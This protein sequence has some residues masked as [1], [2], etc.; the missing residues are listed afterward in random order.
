MFDNTYDSFKKNAISFLDHCVAED[1]HLNPEKIQIDC[2]KVPF[3]GHT[4]SKDGVH[5][6]KAKVELIQ[7]WPIPENVKELQSFLGTVNYLSKFLAFLSD[8]C[9]PLQ[10]LLKNNAEFT[11][12]ETHTQAFNQLKEHVSLNISLQFFDCSKKKLMQAS[13]TLVLSCYSLIQLLGIHQLET[14]L[15]A[16]DLL[17]MLLRLLVRQ[18]QIT[19]ILNMN[20]LV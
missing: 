20:F 13:G 10:G 1:I 18:S 7:N 2:E 4:L 16:L 17:L 3:F 12:T 6:D 5:P 11:W 9:V 19:V 14:F 8:L 15:T